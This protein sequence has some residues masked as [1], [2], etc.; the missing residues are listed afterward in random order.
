MVGEITPAAEA[1]ARLVANGDWQPM[2]WRAWEG[3]D[4]QRRDFLACE[5]CE[6]VA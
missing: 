1:V 4:V 6:K 3:S 5:Q 2:S